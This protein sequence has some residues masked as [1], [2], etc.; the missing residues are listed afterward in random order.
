MANMTESAARRL[1]IRPWQLGDAAALNVAIG[2]SLEHLRP[3]MPWIVMEPRSVA[4]RESLIAR[5]ENERRAGGDIVFG[6][7]LGTVVV[8][9]C[10]LHRRLGPS[11]LEIGYWV[12]AAHLRRGYAASASATLTSVAF[13]FPEIELVEIHCDRANH[14]SQGVPRKLGFTLIGQQ[15]QPVQAPKETGMQEVW[16]TLRSDWLSDVSV[17]LGFDEHLR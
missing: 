15:P 16:R 14:A 12:H 7:F 6:L 2:E 9:G 11:G 13:S 8:G 10:G 3:W 4:D 5:W 1:A 17:G